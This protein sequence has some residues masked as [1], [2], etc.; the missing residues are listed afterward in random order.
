MN[1][2]VR[3]WVSDKKLRVKENMAESRIPWRWPWKDEGIPE[4]D[5]VVSKD[6]KLGEW[7]SRARL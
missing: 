5:P 6:R 7:L 2:G 3:E 1:T 4:R